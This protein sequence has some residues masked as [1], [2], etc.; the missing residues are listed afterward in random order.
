MANLAELVDLAVELDTPEVVKVDIQV[1]T[2]GVMPLPP[3]FKA[4]STDK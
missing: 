4:Q 3:W 1:R 2:G